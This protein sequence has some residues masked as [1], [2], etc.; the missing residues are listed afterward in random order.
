L[1]SS[2]QIVVLGAGSVGCFIGGAWALAGLEISF[3]GRENIGADVAGH[4]IA[5]S[6]LD[7]WK[8]RLPPGAIRFSTRAAA[9]AKADIVLLCVKSNGTA[10]AAKQIALHAKR[11]PAVISF[12]NGISNAELLKGLLPKLDIVQ[13]MVPFNVAYLGKGRWHK[14]VAG[15]LIVKDSPAMRALADR[16]GPGPAKIRLAQDME[17]VAWG[18]LLLNLNNALNALSGKTLLEELK[19]RDYRRV[20]A[21]AMIET[22]DL[23]KAANIEPAQI[24]SIPPKLLPHAIA[25]PDI[26]F[27]NLFLR[28]HKIDAA[29]RSSMYDDFAAGRPTEIDYLNGEVVKLAE[30]LGRDAPVNRAIVELVKQ[31][32]AGVELLWSAEDLRKYVLEGHRGAAIFGY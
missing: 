12:Q 25:I 32:E 22:L 31:R 11:K 18:K 24:G 2:P 5:L 6:D 29:A 13:G 1:A 19:Q 14:G 4:G 20:F 17:A 30:R 28:V 27:R 8:R 21:A 15:D 23:L 9:L 16:V 7:G 3:I 26:I 10:A